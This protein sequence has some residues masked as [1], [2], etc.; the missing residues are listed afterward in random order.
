MQL[1]TLHYML[2]ALAL[3]LGLGAIWAGR[4]KGPLRAHAAQLAKELAA[5]KSA[6]KEQEFRL[7]QYELLWFPTMTYSEKEKKIL[8]AVV[9]V[10]HC[11]KCCVPIKVMDQ[12]EWHCPRCEKRYPASVTDLTVMDSIEALAR[13]YFVERHPDYAG[14]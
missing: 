6:P 9:G 12:K 13:K 5:L 7:E 1:D 11:I 8:K 3:V 4:G 2:G 14:E 10:P